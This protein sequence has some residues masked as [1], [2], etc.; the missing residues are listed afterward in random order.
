M[1]Y[2]LH[3]YHNINYSTHSNFV[4]KKSNNVTMKQKQILIFFQFSPNPN[5]FLYHQFPIFL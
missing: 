2:L 3:V 5:S 1:D 4:E